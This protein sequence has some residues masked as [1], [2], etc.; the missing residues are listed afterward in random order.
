VAE[1]LKVLGEAGEEG[2]VRQRTVASLVSL[3]DREAALDA[4]ID[5]TKAAVA[6]ELAAAEDQLAGLVRE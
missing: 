4:E 5:R 2:R 3:Q 6:A 1:Q